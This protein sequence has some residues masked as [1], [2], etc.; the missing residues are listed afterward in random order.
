[1][2][3]T[4]RDQ[5]RRRRRLIGSAAKLPRGIKAATSAKPGETREIS[6]YQLSAK[7]DDTRLSML[8]VDLPGYGFAFASEEKAKQWQALMKSYIVGRGKS[9]KRILLLIDA[10]HGMKKAD[11]DFLESMQ[12]SLL[13]Q[14]VD[15][16]TTPKVGCFQITVSAFFPVYLTFISS[17]HL[18]SY[19]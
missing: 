3:E 7:V 13:E 8:L 17:L 18:F 9:L 19:N 16:S 11:F 14:T 4:E 2:E 1:M 5:N 12:N 10:R 6:F 15:L